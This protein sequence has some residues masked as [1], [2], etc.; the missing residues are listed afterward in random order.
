VEIKCY[1]PERYRRLATVAGERTTSSLTY[2][3]E[4]P[5]LLRKLRNFFRHFLFLSKYTVRRTNLLEL[6]SYSAIEGRESFR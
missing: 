4:S 6:V 1:F 5:R 2:V 3:K